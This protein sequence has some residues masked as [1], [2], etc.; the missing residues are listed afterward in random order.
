MKLPLVLFSG[1]HRLPRSLFAVV[2][3]L[4]TASEIAVAL[5]SF[6]SWWDTSLLALA[7]GVMST[8]ISRVG[9]QSVGLGYVTGDLNS[10]GKH[11]ALFA[12]G[13]EDSESPLTCDMRAKRMKAL[14][15]VWCAFLVG[16]LIAGGVTPFF[17]HYS[18]IPAILVLSLLAVHPRYVDE[19][20]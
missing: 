2:A 15:A 17:R 8:A 20:W 13:I 5:G 1:P 7:M 19:L 3:I 4:L 16:A 9:Q 14:A 12:S 10:L 18:L 11:L 6:S